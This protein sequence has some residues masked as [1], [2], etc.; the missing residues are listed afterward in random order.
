MSLANGGIGAERNMVQRFG[1]EFSGAFVAQRAPV[2]SVLDSAI[3]HLTLD[4]FGA[5]KLECG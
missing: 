4:E 3:H 5:E 1:N 2:D